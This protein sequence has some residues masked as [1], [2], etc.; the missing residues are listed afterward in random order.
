MATWGAVKAR[1][2]QAIEDT[3]SGAYLWPDAELAEY[4][5]EGLRELGRVW[6][7]RWE[8][9]LVGVAGQGSYALDAGARAVEGV[10]IGGY[11]VGQGHV[12][13]IAAKGYGQRWALVSGSLRFGNALVGGEA[14]VVQVSG[15]WLVPASDAA[16][17]GVPDEGEDLIVWSAA[18]AALMRREVAAGKRR[19]SSGGVG[20]A[21]SV[22]D[23]HEAARRRCQ[24]M[25]SAVLG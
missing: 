12:R 4:L 2:R 9:A 21:A 17:S 1:V 19:G 25:R 14:I 7:R 13:D 20:L 15:L 24:R 8:Q 5:Q 6:P 22:R 11:P 18:W 16:A 3:D 10:T 23:R